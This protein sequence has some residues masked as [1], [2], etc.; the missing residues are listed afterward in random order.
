MVVP[1]SIVITSYNREKL[2]GS[3]IE[4][5]LRQT[6][7]DFELLIW[8]DGSTDN[9]L[10]IAHKYAQE[11]PRVRI[12]AAKHQGRVPALQA[13]IAATQGQ[14]LAWIDSDDLLAP[15]ALEETLVVLAANSKAGMVYTDYW[16]LHNNGKVLGYGQRT[17]V[18]YSPHQLLTN[19]MTFHFRLIRRAVFEEVG[20]IDSQS[21]YTEDYDLCL[22][23]SEATE[24]KH[25]AKPLYYYRSNPES[26]SYQ[27]RAEQI[28][29]TYGATLRA[30]K[31]RGLRDR[32]EAVI[33]TKG[34]GCQMEAWL[35]LRPIKNAVK[36]FYTLPIKFLKTNASFSF[37]STL[38]TTLCLTT[39]FNAQAQTINSASDGTGTII[40][41]TG[42]QFNIQ[43]GSLSGNGGNLFHSFQDFGLSASQTANFLSQPGINNILGRVVGGNA[44][45]I[46][47]LIQITGSNANLFLMNPAG[48][49]FGSNAQ[50]N[51]P[52]SFSATTATG[53]GFEGGTFNSV[54]TND[55]NSLVGNPN[56]FVFNSLQPGAIIN[57]GDLA[58]SEGNNLSL[59][60]GTVAS[61]GTLQAQGGNVTI[62]AVPGSSRVRI[63]QA[64]HILG[65]E[66]E[67]PT[68]SQ[69]DPVPINPLMLPELLT[70]SNAGETGLEVNAQG[71]A[72]LSNSDTTVGVGDVAANQLTA[73][74]A[75][76]AA[77]SNLTL[78]ESN[79]QTTGD[80]DLKAK[81]TV[82]ARDSANQPLQIKA[83][84]NLYIQGDKAIDIL[85]LQHSQTPFVSGGDLSLVSDGL[86]SGDAHYLSGGKF[87][88]LN[89]QG[90][91]GNFVSFYDPIIS[92]TGDVTFGNYT[93]VSLK[94]ETLGSI[95]GGNIIINGADTPGAIPTS[96]PHFTILTTGNGALVLQAG[97]ATIPDLDN[98]A[99]TPQTTGGTTF[100]GSG[101]PTTGS[102][103]VGDIDVG[104][105]GFTHY[106]GPVI[107]EATGNVQTGNISTFNNDDFVVGSDLRGDI[108]ITTTG[109]ITTGAIDSSTN[110]NFPSNDQSFG[111]D[112]NLIAGGQITTGDINSSAVTETFGGAEATGGNVTLTAGTT[113]TTGTIN[114]SA[115]AQEND[116]GG[117]TL[118]RGG[119]VILTGGSTPG[120]NIIF[121]GID[122]TA[123]GILGLGGN[124]GFGGQV[125]VTASNGTVRGLLGGNT[126]ATGG[127]T[128]GGDVS[129]THDG[130]PDNEPFS[131]GD[132]ST[133]GLAG[134]INT[135]TSLL[136]TG[137]FPVLP[138]GGVAAGTPTDITITS[139]NTPPT[140]TANS[141]TGALQDQPF[142]FTFADLNPIT[143]DVNSDNLTSITIVSIDAGILTVNGVT[144]TAGT[145]ISSGDTLVYT[146]P[147]GT[148]GSV[149]G[150]TISVSDGISSTQQPVS[151]DVATIAVDDPVPDDILPEETPLPKVNFDQ[152]VPQ[153]QIDP[154]IQ[155]LEKKFTEDFENY[156]GEE[157][158]NEI[159]SLDEAKDILRSINRETGV[160]P[161][162]IYA[163]FFPAELAA[164]S[165]NKGDKQQSKSNNLKFPPQEDDQLEL[166]LLTA[167]GKIL[168][169]PIRGI[170]RA[171]VQQV[172]KTFRRTITNPSRPNAYLVPSQQLYQWLLAPLEEELQAQGINNLA[173]ILDAGIRSIPVAALHDGEQFVLEKYSL[174]LMPSLSLTDTRYVDV[175]N[176]EVLAMG[177]ETFS[178]LPDLP[179][180]PIEIKTIANN[181]WPGKS[182]LGDK[183]TPGNLKSERANVPFGIIHLATHAEFNAGK[184]NNSYIQ[185]WD[186]KISLDQL[187]QLG[188]NKPAVELM[189]LSACRTAVGSVESELG[190]AGLANQA[191]VKSALGSLWTVSDE[192][193][194]G[195]MATLY[196]QLKVAPI[197]AEALRQA[198]LAMIRGEVKLQDGKLIT[199][200]IEIPLPENL[201][202][203]GDENLNHPYYW[204]AFTMIGSPW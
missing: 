197:K 171:K 88:I 149:N 141:L 31:R 202:A 14:Y 60:G 174:G 134:D 142:T 66:I 43:G 130:G 84:G 153:L 49:V 140:L 145:V 78:V 187:R 75:T 22:R 193:T 129:I 143:G 180:V 138:N 100:N 92:S 28:Y 125:T 77:A 124:Q 7:P 147:A 157:D 133:N 195:F 53:I 44:S 200:E 8:D 113:L 37:F 76:L 115:L 80:L 154:I 103:N 23:L 189:V 107:I 175:K 181:L 201:A 26:F 27:K 97:K 33:K 41:Q 183:F 61:T 166:V 71:E 184:P 99:N 148:T 176:M 89:L 119:N 15:T 63:N 132:A 5:I 196:E 70:G 122:T 178:D 114:A 20:G 32:Y 170:T 81:D 169:K 112:I 62:S 3:A 21:L 167:E 85:A 6:W 163:A 9:S 121:G 68:N 65:L 152:P 50:L 82:Y 10:A 64:G 17:Q 48:M 45:V 83:G 131:I 165:E 118:A 144:A 56:A 188:L 58:V 111:G 30:L 116:G 93:G 74:S 87:S 109:N 155:Q 34:F 156:F 127:T 108:T 39:T 161:A 151:I 204:S 19:F 69:G 162:L 128:Q 11:D 35:G 24:I 104:F 47:G 95:N 55:Y 105:D 110:L 172:A 117:P 98:T 137:A 191:G 192:G 190:F 164:P 203:L 16:H 90:D 186:Q 57:A 126:V 12:I 59:I 79:L 150:F 13:G 18:A 139:I 1:I 158:D 135:G 177:T 4:S 46:N 67:P 94:V 199:P 102:I 160:K 42:N 38:L 29:A 179:A 40:N 2:L 173:F 136:D 25:L 146:P 51:V 106:G 96:D 120:S 168:R 36:Q 101:T 198:Q 123:I 86:I 72:Q 52:G 159:T 54:G 91:G 182:L 194:L 73:E 185:F